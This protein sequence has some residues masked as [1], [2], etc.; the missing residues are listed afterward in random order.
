MDKIATRFAVLG[1][2]V[3][4]ADS[5]RNSTKRAINPPGTAGRLIKHARYY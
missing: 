5:P 3:L 4:A 1:F 2:A